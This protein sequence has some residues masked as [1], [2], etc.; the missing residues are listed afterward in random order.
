MEIALRAALIEHL[1]NDSQIADQLS[2]ITEEAPVRASLP[3]LAIVASASA[4][5]SHKTGEGREIRVALELQ[6]RGDEPATAAQLVRSIENRVNAIPADQ[7]GFRIVSVQFLRARTEQ[8]G[9]TTRAVLLEYRFR[10]LAI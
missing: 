3:W 9:G 10:L 6:A 7:D 4:D 2:A 1:S 8:R 5:W